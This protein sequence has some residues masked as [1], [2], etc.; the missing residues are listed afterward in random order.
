MSNNVENKPKKGSRTF[1]YIMIFVF[2]YLIVVQV[3]KLMTGP[4]LLERKHHVKFYSQPIDINNNK[5]NGLDSGSYKISDFNGK[6]LILSFWAPWCGY[7]A[8]E[9]PHMSHLESQLEKKGY[10]IIPIVKSNEPRD[11]ID[12]FYRRLKINN[13]PTYVTSDR[14]LYGKLGVR[15][16][17]RFIL[18]D[19][20]GKAVADM[21]PNWSSGDIYHLFSQLNEI[22][23][24]QD[25]GRFLSP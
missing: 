19:E 15:G 24:K 23:S 7:C 21:R 14:S 11:K 12:Q 18:V 8:Q 10:K 5:I 22:I 17:P 9:M 6:K 3:S 2:S 4:S 25:Q 1:K 20:G 16:F 13:M